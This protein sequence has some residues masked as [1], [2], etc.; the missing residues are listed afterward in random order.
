M[1]RYFEDFNEG[2]TFVSPG[3]TITEA[4]QV[5]YAGLSGNVGS[6]HLNE[7]KMQETPAGGRLVYGYLVMA[8]LEGLRMN[9]DIADDLEENCPA[10]YG[11]ENVR[12]IQPVM[13]GETIRNEMEVI[14]LDDRDEETGTMT[15]REQA[16]NERDET[17]VTTDVKLVIE[18]RRE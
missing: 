16:V 15:L 3:R 1:V 4:D 9:S 17:V 12:F 8:M 18:K 2:D 6:I 7:A 14:E 5:N 11:M 13:I 10:F